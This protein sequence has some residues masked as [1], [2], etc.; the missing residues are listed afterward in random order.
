MQVERLNLQKRIAYYLDTGGILSAPVSKKR[1][2]SLSNI[3][4]DT[5]I[6]ANFVCTEKH[7]D[8]FEHNPG[9][10]LDD[11]IKCWIIVWNCIKVFHLQI[12]E[13]ILNESI[14]FIVSWY[15]EKQVIFLL[16]EAKMR[17]RD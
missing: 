11:A 3:S 9:K 14:Q 12:L 1:A 8:F 6:E 13:T 10:S 16:I 17:N 5:I 2:I 15:N 4:E 7:R